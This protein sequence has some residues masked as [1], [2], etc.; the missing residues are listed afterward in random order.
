MKKFI[1]DAITIVLGLITLFWG[2]LTR[3]AMIPDAESH[4]WE[5]GQE[6]WSVYQFAIIFAISLLF[7]VLNVII[8]KIGFKKLLSLIFWIIAIGVVLFFLLILY[9]GIY[10]IPPGGE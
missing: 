6:N 8:Q 1:K 7:F 5:S 10:A 3:A 2:M 9:M 4:H